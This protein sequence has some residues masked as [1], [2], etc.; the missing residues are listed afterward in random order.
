MGLTGTVY[1]PSLTQGKR[2]LMVRLRRQQH[3][4]WILVNECF[5]TSVERENPS[6]K[7]IVTLYLKK[8]ESVILQGAKD[9]KKRKKKCHFQEC[10]KEQL[11]PAIFF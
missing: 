4:G 3:Q 6:R 11:L 10:L 1:C 7:N 5:H 8:K 9:R 2:M